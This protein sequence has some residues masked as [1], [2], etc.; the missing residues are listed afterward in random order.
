LYWGDI[1]VEGFV[2]LSRLRNLFPHVES[3]LMDMDTIRQ[4]ENV[5]IEGSGAMIAAPTNLTAAEAEAFHHCLNGNRRLEQERFS[6]PYV[7][8]ALSWRM[9]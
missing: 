1:D 9:R 7:D 8:R 5:Q 6:Q 4:H 3:F 2:I